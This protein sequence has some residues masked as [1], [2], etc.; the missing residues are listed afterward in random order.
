MILNAPRIS[1]HALFGPYCRREFVLADE[2]ATYTH[3]DWRRSLCL[4]ARYDSPGM[5]HLLINIEREMASPGFERVKHDR[6]TTV[7]YTSRDGRRLVVKRYNTKNL[8]HFVRRSVR[9]SRAQNCFDFARELLAAN[10]A[11]APPVAYVEYRAGPLKGRSWVICEH[12]DGTLCLD[13]VLNE[14]SQ[15]EVAEL[16]ARFERLFQRL[17]RLKITH[18]DM[19]ASNFILRESRFPVLIDLDGMRRHSNEA[20]YRAARQ[21]DRERFMKNWRDRPD[22]AMCFSRVEW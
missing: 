10:I 2:A 1:A 21:R 20:S 19:K 11:T 3:R 13:Y 14:A 4:R 5:R 17:A 12:V 9:R 22:L 6:T 15:H 18:G 7:G 8:W 16:A